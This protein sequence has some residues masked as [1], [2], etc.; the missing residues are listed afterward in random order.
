VDNETEF[1]RCNSSGRELNWMKLKESITAVKVIKKLEFE[2]SFMTWVI[3][4]KIQHE[5]S[6][7]KLILKVLS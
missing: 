2:V 5:N 4:R 1:A 6:S 7:Q 3:N